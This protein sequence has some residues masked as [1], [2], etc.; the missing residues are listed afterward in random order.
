MPIAYPI[1]GR[2]LPRRPWI[3]PDALYLLLAQ[4]CRWRFLSSQA[5]HSPLLLCILKIIEMR[6][7]EKMPRIDT[8]RI[9]A[10][11]ANLNAISNWAVRYFIGNSMAIN[12]LSSETHL[13]V[14]GF[15][16]SSYPIPTTCFKVDDI[17]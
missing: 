6:T 14:S 12:D 5:N 2:D 10:T 7:G 1:I 13:P 17:F 8:G 3:A 9:V 11:M 4:F 16:F 15:T